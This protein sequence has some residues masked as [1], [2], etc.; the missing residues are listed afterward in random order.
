MINKEAQITTCWS[1]AGWSLCFYDVDRHKTGL[2]HEMGVT[3]R[4]TWVALGVS[5]KGKNT[6]LEDLFE[7]SE[8]G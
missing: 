4:D 8:E 1:Q 7:V 5:E 3:N 6:A 2:V